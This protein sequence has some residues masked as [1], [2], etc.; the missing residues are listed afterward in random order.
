MPVPTGASRSVRETGRG[1]RLSHHCAP[2]DK[3]VFMKYLT[4][5]CW[6]TCG[7]GRFKPEITTEEE[8]PKAAHCRHTVR[9]FP[10]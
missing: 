2:N 6:D 4:F 3:G 9:R 10:L 1:G 5:S 8:L 7:G